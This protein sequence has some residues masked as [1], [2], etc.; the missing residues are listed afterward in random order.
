MKTKLK[1]GEEVLHLPTIVEA[2]ESS[3]AAAKECAQVI[4]KFLSKD[5]FS[6]P[7]V[8]Y[9][10]IMLVRILSDNPGPTFTKNLDKKFTDTV[11]ELLRMGRDPSVK[12]ILIETLDNFQKEKKHDGN[13]AVLIQMWEK[14]QAKMEKAY[15]PK[16]KDLILLSSHFWLTNKSKGSSQAAPGVPNASPVDN[17][18]QNYFA[19]SH[20]LNRP[21]PQPHELSSRIEEARTSAKLLTQLVQSTPPAEFDQ[22]DLIREFADRCLSASRSI[23]GYISS[24]DPAPDDDTMLTLID[25]NDQLAL[26][27][28]KH[29]RG[30]LQ[31]RKALGTENGT[32]S[33][34]HSPN[35]DTGYTPPPGPPP[36]FTKPSMPPRKPTPAP[37]QPSAEERNTKSESSG[38][39]NA[40]AMENLEDP[41]K[42]PAGTTM[43]SAPFPRDQQPPTDQ[44]FD[45]LGVEPYHPG[46]KPTQSYMG[47]QDS[48][49]GKVAMHGAGRA[50]PEIE[51]EK[52]VVEQ[53]NEKE[54]VEQNH[55]SEEDSYGV[56]PVQRKAPIYRY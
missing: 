24:Q 31:A 53:S 10:G 19:R 36:S 49:I 32:R 39:P 51:T 11:K 28:S 3:P 40:Y 15:G 42:D 47:R 14:E 18:N 56:S 33:G 43:Q 37:T 45:R 12:Q 30:V 2:A 27:M 9:N 26:A 48:A 41:F 4:R 44:F 23:Q 17:H 1:Q 21:L 16:V 35:P 6:R 46:F 38:S 55:I 29:Q 7:H 20:S 22:N 52:E 34:N 54:V 13:L 50:T 8:Q 5:N 25:T